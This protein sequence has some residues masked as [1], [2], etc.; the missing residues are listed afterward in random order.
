M[1]VAFTLECLHL[2]ATTS[3]KNNF[4][5][6]IVQGCFWE[7]WGG[8]GDMLAILLGR[9]LEHI[10]EVFSGILRGFWIVLREGF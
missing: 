5:M 3:L 7:V 4:D 6:L 10:W 8:L 9:I 2:K 1:C